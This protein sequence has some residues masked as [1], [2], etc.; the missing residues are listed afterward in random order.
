MNCAGTL[1]SYVFSV[2]TIGAEACALGDKRGPRG[3][4]GGGGWQAPIATGV[5]HAAS[6]V[7]GGACGAQDGGGA[8]DLD[9]RRWGR[10][11]SAARGE[12]VAAVG[13]GGGV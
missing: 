9:R 7:V 10:A 11:S 3:F 13:R 4:G 1:F 12:H 8:K 5:V 6:S 2:S